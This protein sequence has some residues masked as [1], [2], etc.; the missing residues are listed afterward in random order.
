MSRQ[1]SRL[2]ELAQQSDHLFGSPLGPFHEEGNA[3]YLPQ[4]VHFDARA[5][6]ES[7]RLAVLAGFGRHD[8]PAARAVLAFLEDLVRHPDDSQGLNVSVFPVA[9]VAGLLGGAEERDLANEHWRRSDRPEIR[10]LDQNARL[11]GYQG[12]VRVVTTADSEPAAWVRTVS[13][14]SAHA[15]G[16]EVFTS[17]DFHPWPVWFETVAAAAVRSGPLSI[18]D[19]LPCAP[20][21]VELA[22]PAGWP[23]RHADR[24]LAPLLR[25]LITR[26]RAFL[27]YGQNL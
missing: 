17:E 27:A 23:Q 15:T 24:T 5:A 6:E 11:R 16:V 4:F 19:D 1:L 18:A 10:L 7:L 22:L 25:R 21:E 9:N 20:F 12:F 14:T 2:Y 8:L 13:S 3:Y 26:Y